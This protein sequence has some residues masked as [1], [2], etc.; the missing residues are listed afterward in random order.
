MRG[1]GGHSQLLKRI[2][3]PGAHNGRQCR[4]L[5]VCV[6]DG[7]GPVDT[8][9]G[10]IVVQI[11]DKCDFRFV[12]TESGGDGEDGGGATRTRVQTVA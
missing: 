6:A 12:Q 9:C 2:E 4:A 10:G 7:P 8:V 1:A 5:T 11:R 3:R